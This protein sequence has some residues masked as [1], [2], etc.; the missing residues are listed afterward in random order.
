MLHKTQRSER[1][2]DWFTLDINLEMLSTTYHAGT[3]QAVG[4][5]PLSGGLLNLMLVLMP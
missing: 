4:T 3:D 2:N 1:G 5:V